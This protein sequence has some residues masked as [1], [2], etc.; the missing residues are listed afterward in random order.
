LTGDEGAGVALHAGKMR[1][2]DPEGSH[3]DHGHQGELAQ[4]RGSWK[5]PIR[6]ARDCGDRNERQTMDACR[7]A[8]TAGERGEQVPPLSRE[9]HRRDDQ[10]QEQS[11][12]V[13]NGQVKGAGCRHRQKQR[14]P[15]M[16]GIAC[17]RCRQ[18]AE[19][20]D[21]QQGR[22]DRA[23]PEERCG[24]RR[25]EHEPDERRIQREKPRFGLAHRIARNDRVAVAC[26]PFVPDGIPFVPDRRGTERRRS[27][28]LECFLVDEERRANE[29]D[30][31]NDHA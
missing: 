10:Q 7:G 18:P 9:N 1:H 17:E 19:R 22:Q 5:V 12:G 8:E 29:P 15:A 6:R 30:R 28:N 27:G 4:S 14:A 23:G 2:V 16:F 26:D 20:R 31:Q 3:E 25:A 24:G 11:F 13:R 21:R